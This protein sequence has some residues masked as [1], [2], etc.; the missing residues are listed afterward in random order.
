[1]ESQF[2]SQDYEHMWNKRRGYDPVGHWIGKGCAKL[3]H[4]YK[5]INM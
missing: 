3:H 5:R 2:N 4:L 1:M